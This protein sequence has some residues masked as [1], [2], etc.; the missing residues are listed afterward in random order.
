MSFD[1][2]LDEETKGK[3]M[4][5]T[6]SLRIT[7]PEKQPK[8]GQNN[9]KLNDQKGAFLSSGLTN[10]QTSNNRS[11]SNKKSTNQTYR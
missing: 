2:I 6:A 10:N 7:G 11:D 1:D 5:S 9:K 8:R 3:T 4:S